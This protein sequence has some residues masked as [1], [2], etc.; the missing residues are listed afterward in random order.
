MFAYIPARIGSK[1]IPKKNI[2]LLDGKP[3]ICHVIES[4]LKVEGLQGI[5]ISTD[6]DEVKTIIEQ[7]QGEQNKTVITLELRSQHIADD[8]ST[9]MDLVKHD[10]PRFQQYFSSDDVLFTL[11]TSALVT[12]SFFQQAVTTFQ[13]QVK[14]K[15]AQGLVMSVNKLPNE[16]LLSLAENSDGSITPLFPENYALPTAQ[17]TSL[18]SD[19]GGF[20]AFNAKEVIKGEMFIDLKPIKPIVLPN[21]MG[22][23]VDNPS[24]WEQLERVYFSK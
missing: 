22:I 5:A 3:I 16:A 15:S 23:D 11:A 2:R 6:S 21:N 8:V 20:Y 7:Y 13:T 10:L 19:A 4:L 17:L 12:T 9:F 1:R 18:Y 14:P 24:D